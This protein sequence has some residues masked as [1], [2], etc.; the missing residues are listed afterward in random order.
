MKKL[1]IAAMILGL[2]IP[3]ASYAAGTKTKTNSSSASL[4]KPNASGTKAAEGTATHEMA[5]SA[6][7]T[8]EKSATIKKAKLKVKKSTKKA[9][10][11]KA[12]AKKK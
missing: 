4:K 11:K 9:S 3:T 2:V 6:N 12:A 5:E 8:Q 1:V 7:G 10:T